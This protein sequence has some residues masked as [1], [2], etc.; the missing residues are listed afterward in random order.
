MQ[1]PVS[2][3]TDSLL[4]LG[5][6]PLAG[7]PLRV[8]APT[9]PVSCRGIAIC[10]DRAGHLPDVDLTHYDALLTIEPDAPAPWIGLPAARLDAQVET[11]RRRVELAPFAATILAR[12]LRVTERLDF[13]NALEV[14][15]LAYSTLL[16]GAEFARWH[17][18]RA[19][20]GAGAGEAAVRYARTGDGVTLTLAA[21]DTHNAMTAAMRD[22]LY[23][24]LVNV[25]EDPSGPDVVLQGEGRCFSTGGHLPEFGTARDLAAAH[26]IR[27]E[28]S[29][30][31][32]LHELGDRATVRLHG[33]CIGSGI[34]IAAAASRRSGAPDT[35]VQLPELAMG[36]MP[37]A[38]GTVTLT[39]AIGRHRTAWLA[40]G[41]FR[42]PARTAKAWGLLH[43]ITG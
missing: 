34:E 22:A 40:L 39:R 10:V 33:A 13:G 20:V 19:P 4:D 43:A 37:G 9:D 7:S 28:R 11:V 1:A 26:A 24:A 14:E 5:A 23:E 8:V 18:A 2:D 30:A 17:S 6:S 42:L 25:A 29:C 3:A 16:G 41:G 15:S 21:G 31:R 38:G 12:V 35:F 36:L 27:T 32:L